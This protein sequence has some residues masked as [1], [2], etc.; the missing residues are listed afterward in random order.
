MVTILYEP[1]VRSNTSHVLLGW[2]A[3]GNLTN[4]QLYRPFLDFVISFHPGKS[5]F[6]TKVRKSG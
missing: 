4:Y 1:L 6:T 2:E 5:F 3:K